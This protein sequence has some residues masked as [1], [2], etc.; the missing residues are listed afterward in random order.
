[1][2]GRIS[3]T[4]QLLRKF[5]GKSIRIWNIQ[6]LK[7]TKTLKCWGQVHPLLNSKWISGWLLDLPPKVSK[8]WHSSSANASCLIPWGIPVLALASLAESCFHGSKS[9]KHTLCKL[10]RNRESPPINIV[11][12]SSHVNLPKGIV[13]LS[14]SFYFHTLGD[15]D[16][17][18]TCHD[19]SWSPASPGGVVLPPSLASNFCRHSFIGWAKTARCE[20]FINITS[21]QSDAEYGR[22]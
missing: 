17:I 1:M 14:N 5:M 4:R 12:C 6:N 18:Q 9:A 16:V 11:I 3:F 2:I 19:I 20:V 21:T 10:S 7:V 22:S 13:Q 8:W 15:E